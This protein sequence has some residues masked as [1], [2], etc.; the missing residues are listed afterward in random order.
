MYVTSTLAKCEV[1]L[2]L[3]HRAALELGL[4]PSSVLTTEVDDDPDYH[5]WIE[6]SL[7]PAWRALAASGPIPSHP[8][9][10]NTSLG[11]SHGSLA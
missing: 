8:C 5:D 2:A 3:A 10:G 4:A 6:E 7:R 11:T 9:E 1:A